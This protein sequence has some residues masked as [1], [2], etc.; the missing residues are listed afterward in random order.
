M[1]AVP[2]RYNVS[3]DPHHQIIKTRDPL[4]IGDA[5]MSLPESGDAVMGFRGG[6][7]L[8]ELRLRARGTGTGEAVRVTHHCFKQF[9]Y[10]IG[11]HISRL[12]TFR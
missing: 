2:E 5:A 3:F 12:H 1:C 10:N 8:L 7:S 4:T 11:L 9:Y 6:E